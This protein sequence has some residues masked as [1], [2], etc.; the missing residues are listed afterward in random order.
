MSKMIQW[1]ALSRKISSSTML[2]PPK[3]LLLL[4]A[5]QVLKALVA[6]QVLHRPPEQQHAYVVP[7]FTPFQP[8]KLT[9][10]S[11]LLLLLPLPLPLLFPLPPVPPQSLLLQVRKP[12]QSVDHSLANK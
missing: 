10:Y 2:L 9:I 12:I 5:W 3:S 7:K 4:Q 8:S 1:G 6:L 11:P